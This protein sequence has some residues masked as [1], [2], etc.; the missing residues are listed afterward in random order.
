[1]YCSK[2]KNQVKRPDVSQQIKAIICEFINVVIK[3]V[4][5]SHLMIDTTPV[6]FQ[7]IQF[8][9]IRIRVHIHAFAEMLHHFQISTN[10]QT[11][12][13][14]EEQTQSSLFS[15]VHGHQKSVRRITSP[16]M[17]AREGRKLTFESTGNAIVILVYE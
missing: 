11:R 16:M 3:H 7:R 14:N 17:P 5:C 4:Q 6:D 13:P 8:D 1:M 10:K 9:V 2:I 12:T 15:P